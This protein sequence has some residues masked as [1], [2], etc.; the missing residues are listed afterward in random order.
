MTQFEKDLAYVKKKLTTVITPDDLGTAKRLKRHF[1]DKYIVL[2]SQTD[3]TFINIM[4]ELDAME[5]EAT[6]KI[7]SAYLFR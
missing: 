4:G 1:Y 7:T 6:R 2:V 5:M 3:M